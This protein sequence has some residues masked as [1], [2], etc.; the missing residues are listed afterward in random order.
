LHPDRI[1]EAFEA[2]DRFDLVMGPSVDGGYYLIGMRKYHKN[3][4]EDIPWSTA[5]VLETTI[6]RAR[7]AG[8]LVK[9][10]P[11]WRDIDTLDDLLWLQ[12]EL[13]TSASGRQET[14]LLEHVRNILQQSAGDRQGRGPGQRGTES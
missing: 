4:F 11:R 5:G 12:G 8:H 9:L 13:S 6:A 7:Q 10:L 2:L 14:Q 3:L 1:E